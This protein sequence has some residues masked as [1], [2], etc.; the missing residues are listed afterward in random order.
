MQVV[1]NIKNDNMMNRLKE[2]IDSF[3][4][5]IELLDKNDNEYKEIEK[6]KN[7]NNKRYSLDEVR[8]ILNDS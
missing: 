5:D 8:K 6:I 7:E 3:K 4:N 1:L 2:F